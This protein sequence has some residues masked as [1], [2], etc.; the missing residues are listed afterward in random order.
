MKVRL[1]WLGV[2]IVATGA[3]V[4]S[5][6]GGIN[7]SHSVSPASFFLPG[8]MKVERPKPAPTDPAAVNHRET[9]RN[10]APSVGDSSGQP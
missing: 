6:C 8:L 3:V 5:G 10:A 2:V 9:A 4:L 1:R 7:A